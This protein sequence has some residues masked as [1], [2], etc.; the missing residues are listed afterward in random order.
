MTAAGTVLDTRPFAA[1]SQDPSPAEGREVSLPALIQITD[2]TRTYQLGDLEVPVLK[3]I[4]LSIRPGEYVALMGASGSGKT[5]LMN[6][7]GC[8]D[9][10]TSGSYLLQG[11]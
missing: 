7:L 6:T 5:T 2:I 4:S 11:V 1:T 10:P 8:L 3:G 9:R